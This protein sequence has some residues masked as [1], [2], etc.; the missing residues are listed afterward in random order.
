MGRPLL[1]VKEDASSFSAEKVTINCTMN[2]VCVVS[3]PF[4]QLM[5]EAFLPL[6]LP[7]TKP[8]LGCE[9]KA[10]G[11]F[12][13][14]ASVLIINLNIWN[15]AILEVKS[16]LGANLKQHPTG[17]WHRLQCTKEIRSSTACFGQQ[18]KQDIHGDTVTSI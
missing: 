7:V 16:E 13:I 17:S 1:F 3:Q 11:F 2:S 14:C 9:N 6:R 4:T 18:R 5:S 10:V 8:T 12:L 15:L